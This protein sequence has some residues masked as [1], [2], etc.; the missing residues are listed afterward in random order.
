MAG[1]PHTAVHIRPCPSQGDAIYTVVY[2][3]AQ[4]A[5]WTSVCVSSRN[6]ITLMLFS[7]FHQLC[8]LWDWSCRKRRWLWSRKVFRCS[9]F[10]SQAKLFLLV[11]AEVLGNVGDEES[12]PSL[13]ETVGRRGRRRMGLRRCYTEQAINHLTSS[14]EFLLALFWALIGNVCSFIESVFSLERKEGSSRA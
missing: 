5:T 14:L 7:A 6:L 12:S 4:C 13:C 8:T 10:S 2:E 11:W 9:C 3:V 1:L